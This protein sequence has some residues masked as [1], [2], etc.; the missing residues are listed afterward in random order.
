M[1]GK[2]K[3]KKATGSHLG[4]NEKEVNSVA[5]TNLRTNMLSKGAYPYRSSERKH[6]GN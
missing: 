6:E 4:T 1:E 2:N 3:T 5:L